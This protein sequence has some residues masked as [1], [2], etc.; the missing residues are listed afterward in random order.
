[1]LGERTIDVYL[2]QAAYWR[3]IS[4][5]VWEYTIGGYQVIKKWL[6]YREREVL[7]RS[8]R[9]EEARAV[10]EMARR[11]TAIILLGPKLDANYESVKDNVYTWPVGANRID[12]HHILDAARGLPFDGLRAGCL[13]GSTAFR[14][15]PIGMIKQSL[16][17]GVDVFMH[18]FHDIFGGG[19]GGEDFFH[20]EAFELS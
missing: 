5:R 18:P 13:L 11:I 20:A 14:V 2:N 8:L 19:A 9:L 1:M 16:V 3:N 12:C 7:G 10:M 4:L 6:S 15:A 17:A